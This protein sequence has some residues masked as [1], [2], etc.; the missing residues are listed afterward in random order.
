MASKTASVPVWPTSI[1]PRDD[2]Y[3]V[4]DSDV[5][6][7]V[8]L[9]FASEQKGRTFIRDNGSWVQIDENFFDEI[10]DPKYYTE[11]VNVDFIK[12]FDT[13]QVKGERVPVLKVEDF[14]DKDGDPTTVTAA[15]EDGKCPPATSDIALNIKNRQRAIEVAEYGPLNPEQPND[16]YWKDMADRWSV[17]PEDAKK[18]LCGNCVFFYVTTSVKNCIAEGLGGTDGAT[19]PW[20]SIDA[21]ELGYCEAFD[22]KCASARTCAAWATGGPITDDKLQQKGVEK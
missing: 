12:Y 13:R 1:G 11:Y 22:F 18:S 10:D 4:V 17:S 21:G 6:D 20:D 9:V 15:V 16:M 3:V 2:L 14:S 7:G 19:D 5:D 8:Y